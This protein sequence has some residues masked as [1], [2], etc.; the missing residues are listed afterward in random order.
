MKITAC[1]NAWRLTLLPITL[2][3]TITLNGCSSLLPKPAP[4]PTFYALD[5][6]HKP[7]DLTPTRVTLRAAPATQQILVPAR[8]NNLPV[9]SIN[10]PHAAAGF[11]SQRIIFVRKNHQL[12][13]FAQSEWIDT[14]ARMIA[15]LLV[16]AIETSP[17]QGFSAVVATPTTAVSDMRLDTEILRLQQTFSTSPSQVRFTV[18]TYLVDNAT[19]KV[20]TSQEFDAIVPAATDDPYGGVVAANTAVQRVLAQ[21]ALVAHETGRNWLTAKTLALS[22]P[23]AATRR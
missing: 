7:M 10:P 4:Q 16:E 17:E 22:Q 9:L 21:V 20:L 23:V 3:A 14:P 19:R 8:T 2:V 18:R 13:Y 6:A 11:D 1:K 5:S 15:P 12:E